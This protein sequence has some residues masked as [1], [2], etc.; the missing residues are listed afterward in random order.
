MISP[1]LGE[2]IQIGI[3]QEPLRNEEFVINIEDSTHFQDSFTNQT[4]SPLYIKP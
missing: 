3:F 1:R 4:F 2:R